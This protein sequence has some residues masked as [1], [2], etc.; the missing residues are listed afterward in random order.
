MEMNT[1]LQ[2]EHPITEMVSG[3]DLVEEQINIAEGKPLPP[4]D[5]TKD[6]KGWAMEARICA[7]DASRDFLPTPGP[8]IHLRTPSGPYV[9]TDTGIYAGSEITPDFDPMIAKVIAWGP[10]RDKARRRLD[11]ALMEFT[12]K[13]LTTNTMFLRQ[14]LAYKPFVDGIYD[15]G[16]IAKYFKRSPVWYRDEHRQVA[17]LGAAIFNFE[18]EK[19]LISQISVK[20]NDK[21]RHIS[22][23]RAKSPIRSV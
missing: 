17:L 9:R 5:F 13:G 22:G 15:T 2:V 7:E 1:R 10:T 6:F 16:L 14:I 23:W 19:K 3:L 21:G 12:I 18:K 20:A 11:R 8:I 4:Y